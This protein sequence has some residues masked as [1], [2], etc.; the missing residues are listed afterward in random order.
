MST[1]PGV[2]SSRQV[3][4]RSLKIIDKC[5]NIKISLYLETSGGQS[6]DLYLNAVYFYAR[7]NYT[8]MAV[9]DRHFPA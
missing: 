8:S 7:V 3:E 6:F 1:A 5:W 2:P 9:L 4:Q